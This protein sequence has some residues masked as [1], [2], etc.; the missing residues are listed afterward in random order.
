MRD[1]GDSTWDKLKN[2]V[3][4]SIQ[5][6]RLECWEGGKMKKNI[7]RYFSCA[8]GSDTSYL[9]IWILLGIGTNWL[10]HPINVQLLYLS[11]TLLDVVRGSL[12]GT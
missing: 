1:A 6:Q 2:K 9:H 11:Q 7:L 5:S 8:E 4:S 3:K 10:F 12:D